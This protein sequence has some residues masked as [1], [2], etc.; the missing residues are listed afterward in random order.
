VLFLVGLLIG[1]GIVIIRALISDRLRRR[2]E[3][4]EVIGT[5]VKLS[6]RSMRPRSRLPRRR[7][8]ADGRALDLRRMVSH[9]NGLATPLSIAPATSRRLKGLAIVAVDNAHEV[10]PAVAELAAW[11][12]KQ[13]KKVVVADLAEG[14]PVARLLG[15]SDPGVHTVNSAGAEVVVVVPQRDD[16]ALIG[17]IPGFR[18]QPAG[19][20]PELAAACAS[21][22]LLFTMTTLDPASGG[23][24]LSTWAADAAALVTAGRSSSTRIRAVGDMIRLAGLRLASVVLTGADKDDESLGL[25]YARDEE[26]SSPLAI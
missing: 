1:M 14:R 25:V 4:A 5:P 18:D 24:Y 22:D 11:N 6:V 17:P 9:L 3:I 7:Q 23:D 13:G 12:A 2:D 16:I 21:A 20:D 10:A 26:S 8:S 19:A 15:V